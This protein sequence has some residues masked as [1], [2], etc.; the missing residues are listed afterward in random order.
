MSAT[1]EQS[2]QGL[3]NELIAAAWLCEQGYE[4]FKNVLPRGDIDLVTIKGEEVRRIDVKTLG[5]SDNNKDW[6]FSWNSYLSK[7]Q[8]DKG[9]KILFV[10]NG[11]VGWNRDY[12][13]SY[14]KEKNKEDA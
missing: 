8:Q 9:I 6:N 12:F 13:P 14:K 11:I 3:I 1:A 7:E 4:V 10:K 2:K 5:I